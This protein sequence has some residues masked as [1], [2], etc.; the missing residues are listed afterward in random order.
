MKSKTVIALFLLSL[1]FSHSLFAAPVG[2]ARGLIKNETGSPLE[3]VLISFLSTSTSHK[4][5]TYSNQKGEFNVRLAPGVYSLKVDRE[6]YKPFIK[7]VRIT[8]G[9]VTAVNLILRVLD[10]TGGENDARNWDIKT[11]LRTAPDKRLIFRMGNENRI[12]PSGEAQAKASFL[13]N[14]MVKLFSAPAPANDLFA[15]GFTTSFALSPQTIGKAKYVTAGLL[16]PWT[17]SGKIKS[18]LNY[19]INNRYS[20]NL[21]LGYGRRDS[22]LEIDPSRRAS[23]GSMQTSLFSLE[24][25][26]KMFDWMTLTYGF[27]YNRVKS[28]NARSV[29]NPEIQ[30]LATPTQDTVL[31]AFLTSKRNREDNLLTLPSGEVIDIGEPL[32]VT[33]SGNELVVNGIRHYELSFA[34]NLSDTTVE[35]G[36]FMDRG[37]GDPLLSSIRDNEVVRLTPPRGGVLNSEGIRAVYHRQFIDFLSGSLSYVYATGSEAPKDVQLLLVNGESLSDLVKRG[38]FHLVVTQIDARVDK[39]R[40]NI[41]TILKWAPRAPIN[42]LDYF[43][44]KKDVANSGV[45][46]FIRQYLPIPEFLNLISG[47]EALVDIRNLLGQNSGLMLTNSG[48]IFVAR[49]PRSFRGGILFKF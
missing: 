43:S 5:N 31:K 18:V 11:V 30:F 15:G 25:Q 24:T 26:D 33:R 45:S 10:L 7:P 48:E 12:D 46:L 13:R 47:W 34:K 36:A 3:G 17:N 37:Y 23:L 2:K 1:T 32:A 14:S 28:S 41:S 21:S 44:D 49:R 22:I 29:I 6:G 40:S 4:V 8:A 9:Q 19:D 38:T 16:N 39:T 20:V 27:T 35:L 42:T